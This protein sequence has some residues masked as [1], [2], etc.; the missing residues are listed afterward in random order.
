MI[1]NQNAVAGI[2]GLALAAGAW[3]VSNTFPGQMANAG[4]GPD[5]YPKIIAACLAF[6]SIV[7]IIGGPGKSAKRSPLSGLALLKFFL[8][9]LVLGMYA[10]CISRLGYFA[11]TILV[12]IAASL[13]GYWEVDV[14]KLVYACINSGF[15]CLAIFCTFRLLFKFSL[16]SGILF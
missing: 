6:A 4:P 7:L 16:P 2:L 13:I 1:L 12:S 8:L 9:V 3:I 11:S 10:F 5:F 14:K 15:I